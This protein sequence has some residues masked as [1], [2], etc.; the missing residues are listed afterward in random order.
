MDTT[1]AKSNTI[2]PNLTLSARQE[3]LLYAALNSNNKSSNIDASNNQST[4]SFAMAPGSFT[5]S[6]LQAPGSGTLNG[7]DD[8]PF[9]DYDYEFDAD[10]SFDYDFSNDSQGQ[11]IGKLPGSSSDGDADVHDKRSHPDDDGD[12]EE[13]GGKRREGDEK[14]TKKPGRKPLTSEPTSVSNLSPIRT[15]SQQLLIH[16]VEA[17]GSKSCRSTGIPGTQGKAPQGFRDKSG[18]PAESFGV[19]K[20]RKQYPACTN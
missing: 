8:S 18:R 10:G 14:T 19:S 2:S 11:M 4:N 1:I 13:G 3:Q 9:I 5:E 6:P 12:E 15:L 16:A 20:S 7:F 17:Q